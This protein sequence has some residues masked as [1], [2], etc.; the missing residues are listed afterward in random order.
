[1]AADFDSE[2]LP[3]HALERRGM[4]R[5]GPEL[6]LH[7]ARRAQLHQVVV[8]AIVELQ[9]RDGLRV[10]AIEALRQPQN[11]GER[12]NGGPRPPPHRAEALVLSLR[13]RLPVI[14]GDERDRL[15]LA[16]LESA[17]VAV[18]HEV[19]RMLVMALVADVHADVVQN[20][21]VL[22]PFPLAIGQPV[23]RARLVEQGDGQP[24]D[25]L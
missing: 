8:T 3:H 9:A 22:E 4:P 15:D 20:G 5:G 13:R 23:N 17:E 25:V 12:A 7:I 2:G 19:V 18:L 11:R 6:Q 16:G 1:V 10:T 14:A 21:G 24:R